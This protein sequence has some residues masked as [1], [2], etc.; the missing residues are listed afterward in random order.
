MNLSYI[1]IIISIISIINS[2]VFS[3]FIFKPKKNSNPFNFNSEIISSFNNWLDLSIATYTTRYIEEVI[4]KELVKEEELNI[5]SEF[6]LK[7][8]KY[9]CDNIVRF[10]PEFYKSYMTK[11]YGESKLLNAIY[12]RVRSVFIKYIE[13]E[14]K[15]RLNTR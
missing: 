5:G 7:G 12:D 2:I 11:F 10:M 4:G 8:I 6:A 3:Y 14:R 9:V 15:R 13:N 1:S